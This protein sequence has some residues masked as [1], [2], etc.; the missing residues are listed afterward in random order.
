MTRVRR[1]KPCRIETIDGR[2]YAA[3]SKIEALRAMWRDGWGGKAVTL[4]RYMAEVAKRAYKW[5]K[6]PVRTD[7]AAVF[8]QDLQDSKLVLVTEE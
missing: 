8:L 3:P 6:S 4:P 7:D 1:T 5:S 2:V